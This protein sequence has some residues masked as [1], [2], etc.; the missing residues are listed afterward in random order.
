MNNYTHRHNRSDGAVF[1]ENNLLNQL[2]IFTDKLMRNNN[3]N[4]EFPKNLTNLSERDLTPEVCRE[5]LDLRNIP[6]FTIDCA[7]TQD[8]DDAVSLS[9]SND[10]YTLGVHIADVAA[11]VTPGSEL[12]LVALSRGTSIYFPHRTIPMLPPVLSDSL[13]SLSSGEDRNALSIIIS[14]DREGDVRDYKFTKS[15]IHSRLKGTYTEVNDILNG[16]ADALITSKYK[17]LMNT[18]FDMQILSEKLRGKRMEDGS[19]ASNNDEP[20]I[21]IENGNIEIIPHEK[22]VAEGII[23]E[24]MVIANRLVVEYFTENNLPVI[25]RVQREKQTLAGYLATQCHHAELALERYLHFTSPIR[26]LADLKVHQVLTAHLNGM[27]NEML[28]EIFGDSMILAAERADKRN[29]TVNNMYAAC[30]RFCYTQFFA[31][32]AE[33]KFTGEVVGRDRR[34]RAIIRLM[35]SRIRIIGAAGLRLHEGQRISAKVRVAESGGGCEVYTYSLNK[36]QAA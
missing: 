17:S 24:F 21:V 31:N 14:L 26:R 8:M 3:I 12:E 15:L 13:C 30:R 28:H 19:G 4:I 1:T 9:K 35:E 27:D 16:C 2:D 18:L 6:C 34:N 32:R 23:E 22:G 33:E 36:Y 20:K 11:Y 29:K 5:R 25:Y 10:G 7:D